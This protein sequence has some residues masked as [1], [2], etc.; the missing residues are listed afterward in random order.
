VLK[1]GTGTDRDIEPACTGGSENLI[2]AARRDP[3][4]DVSR[5][6][7]GRDDTGERGRVRGQAAR[8]A[9]GVDPSR[10]TNQSSAR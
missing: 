1:T 6:M 10:R 2:L 7:N 8:F 5:I 3:M 4:Q 9:Q